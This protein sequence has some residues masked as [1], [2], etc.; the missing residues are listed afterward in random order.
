MPR[1]NELKHKYKVKELSEL[2]ESYRTKRG[3][4]QDELAEMVGM[5]QQNYSRK[6][7]AN[8]YKA[9]DLILIFDA[10]NMPEEAI[11]EGMMLR[12]EKT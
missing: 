5:S 2:I 11:L 6:I 8:S 4:K 7:K 1:V 3:L 9:E 10:L 12:R